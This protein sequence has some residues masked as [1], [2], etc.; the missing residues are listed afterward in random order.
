MLG[1]HQG[2]S[3][4]QS[5]KDKVERHDIAE[6]VLAS[7]RPL[8]VDLW[9][10]FES[11]GRYVLVDKFDIAGGGVITEVLEDQD[12]WAS[13]TFNDLVSKWDYSDIKHRERAEKYGHKPKLILLTGVVGVN[14]K[15][16]AKKIEK[17]MFDLGLKVY[18]SSIGNIL[19]NLDREEN[20]GDRLNH[21][22]WLGELSHMMI[23]AG[24]VVVATATNSNDEEL[25]ML[26]SITNRGFVF[27]VNVGEKQF[28]ENDV[29]LSLAS[30]A[31][32][33]ENV[34]KI[35]ELVKDGGIILGPSIHPR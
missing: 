11:T 10:E 5:R 32:V 17:K 18:F 13:T 7:R 21:F 25:N 8:A 4:K 19:R 14:K 12:E 26:H 29:D 34:E 24:L 1:G 2:I 6:C 20:R 23:D 16:I 28:E 30:D 31:T 27:I 15:A 9:N 35:L 3:L 22:K 33:D